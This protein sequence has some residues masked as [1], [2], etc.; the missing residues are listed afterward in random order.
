VCKMGEDEKKPLAVQMFESGIQDPSRGQEIVAQL[1]SQ[2]RFELYANVRA[3]FVDRRVLDMS[4]AYCDALGKQAEE[5]TKQSQEETKRAQE[6]TKRTIKHE[7]EETKRSAHRIYINAIPFVPPVFAMIILAALRVSD[8]VLIG[9]IVT[10]AGGGSLASYRL[11]RQGQ[12]PARLPAA[13]ATPPGSD[14][15]KGDG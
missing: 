7:E 3:E 6:E 11:I 13:P 15:E 4:E 8:P 14:G 10:L 5:G 2:P 12:A 9:A 1:L